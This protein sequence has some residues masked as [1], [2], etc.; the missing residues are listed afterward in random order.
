MLVVDA[1]KKVSA[2]L[3]SVITE[4][5]TG[6]KNEVYDKESVTV[7]NLTRQIVDL[8]AAA[9]QMRDPNKGYVRV[10]HDCSEKHSNSFPG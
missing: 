6:L 2:R 9:L 5:D 8:P 3:N 10:V 4:L 1:T 7:I